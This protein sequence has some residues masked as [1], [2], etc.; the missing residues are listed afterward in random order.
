MD[1]SA[2]LEAEIAETRSQLGDMVEALAY[3]TD[4]QARA[5]DA[6][7]QA[8]AAAAS[9]ALDV[10][11]KIVDA[12]ADAAA[13]FKKPKSRGP[14]IMRLGIALAAAFLV[15]RWATRD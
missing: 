9:S 14:A 7:S 12:A 4:V 8:G 2:K 10:R 6:V 3:K 15:Y 11:D 13:E 5:A 1:D